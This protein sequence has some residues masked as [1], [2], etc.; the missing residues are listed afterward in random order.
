MTAA[1]KSLGRWVQRITGQK[2]RVE[3]PAQAAQ[4]PRELDPQSLSKVG[5]GLDG[6]PQTPNKGW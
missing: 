6:S 3:K 1:G 2:A 4:R 5:G